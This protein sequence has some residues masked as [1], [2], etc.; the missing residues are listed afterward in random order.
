MYVFT[1]YTL[2]TFETDFELLPLLPVF[3]TTARLERTK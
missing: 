3:R 2:R 1:Y